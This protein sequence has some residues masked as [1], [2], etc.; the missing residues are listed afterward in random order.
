MTTPIT[1]VETCG[2]PFCVLQARGGGQVPW[3][4]PQVQLRTPFPAMPTAPLVVADP[5]TDPALLGTFGTP[6]DRLGPRWVDRITPPPARGTDGM[7]D[8][9]PTTTTAPATTTTTATTAVPPANVEVPIVPV[10][11]NLADIYDLADPFTDA[12][13]TTQPAVHDARLD[14]T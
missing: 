11:A 5:T 7:T 1:A 9:V 6:I 12:G 2:C 10:G 14:P 8:D 4:V 3:Q 13:P